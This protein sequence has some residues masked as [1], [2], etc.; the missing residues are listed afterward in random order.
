M[1][2][3]PTPTATALIALMR[4]KGVGRRAALRLVDR[5][6]QLESPDAV[7][8]TISERVEKAK[9]PG[10]MFRD[11]WLKVVED[12]DRSALLGIQALA[13]HD[14]AYPERLRTIPDPP[15]VLFVKGQQEGLAALSL[16]VVG[17]REPTGYGVKVA[18]KLAASAATR[19]FVIVSGLALGCDTH[20]HEGCLD[21]QGIGVAVLAHGLDKVYPASN[22]GLAERL[23]ACGGALVSEY[24]IGMTPLR[25][26]FAE[27]DRI[28]SGLADG[29]FVVETDVT[30]GTMHTV[31]AARGQ[32]RALACID[33]PEAL[34]HEN[35]TRGNRML[36]KERRAV[37]IADGDALGRF[38]DGLRAS[39]SVSENSQSPEPDGDPQTSMGF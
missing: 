15:A 18:R 29:V 6:F 24:P 22:R 21:V 7:F 3:R 28:Q 2:P 8:D 27:R 12:L 31:N 25:T 5:S 4:L 26:A 14:A 34:W 9:L 36:I 30:G 17:T 23:L 35:K 1:T 32:G 16:A 37:P 19:G 38:L 10:A 11:V 33:H 39:R 20:G 13:F